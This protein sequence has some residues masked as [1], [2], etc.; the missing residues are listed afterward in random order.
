[1]D[2]SFKLPLFV[3]N[4]SLNLRAFSVMNVIRPKNFKFYGE[5]ILEHG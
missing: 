5:Q 4:E 2:G 1:M 3:I